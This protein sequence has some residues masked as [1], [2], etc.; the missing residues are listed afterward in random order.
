[1]ERL[2]SCY[3]DKMVAGGYDQSMMYYRIHVQLEGRKQ[4]KKRLLKEKRQE[5][6]KEP[7]RIGRKLQAREMAPSALLKDEVLKRFAQEMSSAKKKTVDSLNK[8]E[9]E[10]MFA[11]VSE[12]LTLRPNIKSLIYDVKPTFEEFLEFILSTDLRGII[13]NILPT[14]QDGRQCENQM[15]MIDD[16]L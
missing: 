6:Y 3:L 5:Q 11:E 12:G 10:K 8:K 4:I 9:I 7:N 2:L 16:Q 1:M 13:P 14:M 15:L